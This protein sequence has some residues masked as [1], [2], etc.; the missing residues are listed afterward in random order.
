MFVQAI[1]ID[2]AEVNVLPQ[3]AFRCY[4]RM[5]LPELRYANAIHYGARRAPGMVILRRLRVI[6][7]GI[8]VEGA[9][10]RFDIAL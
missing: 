1:E 3:L 5:N 7:N 10:Q 6:T 4:L 2:F 9:E 8:V